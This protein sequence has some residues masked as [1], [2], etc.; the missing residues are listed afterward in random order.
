MGKK[1]ELSFAETLQKTVEKHNRRV[2]KNWALFR[3][4][5]GDVGKP[6]NI[7]DLLEKP[8]KER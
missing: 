7:M 6:I 3:A 2:Q 4:Y 1:K 5:G 8:K